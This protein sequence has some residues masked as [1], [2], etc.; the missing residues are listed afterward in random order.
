MPIHANHRRSFGRPFHTGLS[1]V[2]VGMVRLDGGAV[3]QTDIERSIRHLA[4]PMANRSRPQYKPLTPASLL[5]PTPFEVREEERPEPKAGE[6]LVRAKQD[7]EL[8][9]KGG[10][11]GTLVLV[12]MGSSITYRKAQGADSS[13]AGGRMGFRCFSCS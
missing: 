6:V 9:G 2:S 11:I 3:C 10:V 13:V 5:L 12:P 8:L 7:Q 1:R 4:A